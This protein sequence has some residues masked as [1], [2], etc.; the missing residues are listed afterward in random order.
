M[1]EMFHA[2]SEFV[3]MGSVKWSKKATG[4]KCKKNI[5]KTQNSP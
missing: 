2:G 5:R 3:I 4:K 1:F